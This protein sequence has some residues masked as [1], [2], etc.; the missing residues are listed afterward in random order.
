MSG[1]DLVTPTFS[2]KKIYPNGKVILSANTDMLVPPTLD[3]FN[4][5]PNQTIST[6][7]RKL[8]EGLRSEID[9]KGVYRVMNIEIE[10]SSFITDL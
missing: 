8:K 3:I 2:I 10:Q 7:S 9:E 1:L 6:D 4:F 5:R